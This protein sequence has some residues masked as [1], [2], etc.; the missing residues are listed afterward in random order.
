MTGRDGAR[1]GEGAGTLD[2]PAFIRSQTRLTP[3]PLVPEIR[4]HIAADA[5][6]LWQRAEQQAGR[7]QLPPPFWGFPWAGGQALAR[8]VLDNPDTVRHRSVLDIASGSGLVA[9]AALQAGAAAVTASE[10]DPLASAAITLN[11]AANEVHPAAIVGDVLGGEVA[12]GEVASGEVAGG[13]TAAGV[14]VVLAGDA[15]YERSLAGLLLPFLQR[16]RAAGTLVLVGDPGRAYLPRDLFDRVAS[17][18]VPVS[19]VLEDA[20]LKETAVWRFR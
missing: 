17:Y 5:F 10:I 15:F 13:G 14:E 20:N 6:D 4:L 12:S 2:G 9:I 11:C 18:Q 16:S 19:R 8:Y 7:E 1:V 3:V